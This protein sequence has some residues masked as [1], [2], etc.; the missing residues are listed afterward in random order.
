M[1]KIL[2]NSITSKQKRSSGGARVPEINDQ[3]NELD[4]RIE[5]IQALIPLGL[6]AVQDS[7]EDEVN[8]LAGKRYSRAGG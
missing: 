4:A 2:P 7:L 5:L 1:K 6:R 8:E 3:V